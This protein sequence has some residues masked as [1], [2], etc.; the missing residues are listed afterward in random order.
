[1]KMFK[2]I[3][4]LF[5]T[6]TSHYE[7]DEKINIILSPELYWVRIFDI[8]I[9]SKSD[10]VKVMPS[11]FESFLDVNNYKF[12]VIA[13]EDNKK[14]CFAYDE[15]LITKTVE[16]ANLTLNQISNIFF[17]Q[18]EFNSMKSLHINDDY[19]SY[20]DDILVK[21]PKEFVADDNV[22]KYDL[23]HIILSKKKI[24]INVANKYIDNK[25]LYIL[26]FVFMILAFINLGKSFIT[27]NNINEL[28]VKKAN[29]KQEYKML[30]TMM[31]T[32]SMIRILE[33]K[34]KKQIELRNILKKA[35]NSKKKKIKKISFNNGQVYYE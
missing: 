24:H 4:T 28:I 30:P 5:L 26:N 10:V 11:F 25:N 19:F 27:D 6:K 13:L 21:I 35:F 22:S 2:S 33:N 17:A 3:K 31:Q 15:S 34:Q 14:L 23:E 20:Q 8:P 1:M 32:K 9:K 16:N 18:T 12:Y 29:I 7:Y